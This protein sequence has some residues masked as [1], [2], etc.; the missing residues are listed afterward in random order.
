[1]SQKEKVEAV[2]TKNKTVKQDKNE[3][4]FTVKTRGYSETFR[5]HIDAKTQYDTL[6]K[7]SIKSKESTKLELLEH[8]D[9][10]H[11]KILESV[12][13]TSAFFGEVD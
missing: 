2:G 9:K 13:I 10:G 1:M 8:D 11:N 3:M 12:N 5:N 7:R 6:K 4:K